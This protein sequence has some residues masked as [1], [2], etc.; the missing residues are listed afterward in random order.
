MSRKKHALEQGSIGQIFKHFIGPLIR[1]KP[2]TWD[3]AKWFEA[4]FH[5]DTR[6]IERFVVVKPFSMPGL[7]CA[8]P[9]VKV[10]GIGYR[11]VR[12]GDILYVRTDST[13]P[14]QIDVEWLA[15]SRADLFQL[16]STQWGWVRLHLKARKVDD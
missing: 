10:Q 3:L 7:K 15:K 5:N 12:R 14:N 2:H 9:H 16:D 13:N 4:V 11:K 6:A 1:Y 8:A